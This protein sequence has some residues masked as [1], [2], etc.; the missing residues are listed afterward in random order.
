MSHRK[1][2][3]RGPE[4]AWSGY[5]DQQLLDLQ[6]CNLKLRIQDTVFPDRMDRLYRELSK[7]GI[8]FRPH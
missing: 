2:F 4:P 1:N 5:S 6:F 8:H 7:R 3:Y